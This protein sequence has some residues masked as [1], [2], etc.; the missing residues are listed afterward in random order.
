[1]A[2]TNDEVIEECNELIR[3]GYDAI[4]AYEEAIDAIS[5]PSLKEQ[6][7]A[8]LDDHERHVRELTALVMSL[9]GSP[10][11]QTD[12]RGVIKAT[13]MKVEG[14]IETELVVMA[15]HS[16]E[17]VLNKE[18]ASRANGDFPKDV[19]KVIQ[20]NYGDKKRHLAWVDEYLRFRVWEQ[21]PGAGA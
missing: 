19:L 3:F 8:F 5:E 6:L 13:M 14:L 21:Q 11:E 1:M 15:M 2:L 10:P 20:R 16:N 18:Y 7:A 12:G 9:G 17:E 4:G